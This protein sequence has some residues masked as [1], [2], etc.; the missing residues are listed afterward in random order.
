MKRKQIGGLR[1]LAI[2]VVIMAL[3][4]SW[5]TPVFGATTQDV[6]IT[7]TPS[8]IAISN[9]PASWAAGIITANTDED[10]GNGYFT[11]TNTSTV[12]IDISMYVSANWTHTSGS[13]DWTYGAPAAN[14]GRLKVSSADGGTGGSTGAGNFDI[15]LVYGVGGAL[16]VCDNVST[17]TSP[18]WEMQ[19]DAPSSFTHGDG[20]SANVTMTAV[21]E[22]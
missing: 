17:A 8:Y 1:Y 11:I 9:A 12:N 5:A 10:T 6:T 7:A 15:T 21:L 4:L 19:L 18:T 14:T 22:S 2:L 13:N 20:Q 16:L 3:I